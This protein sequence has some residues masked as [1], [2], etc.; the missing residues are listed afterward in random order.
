MIE[1]YRITKEQFNKLPQLDRIE[2]T[3]RYKGIKDYYD[4]SA[5]FNILKMFFFPLIFVM[6]LLYIGFMVDAELNILTDLLEKIIITFVIMG[7]IG[8]PI[9]FIL[10]SRER[11]EL[12]ALEEEYFN[13]KSEVKNATKSR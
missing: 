8:L 12:K 3:I 9:D 5:C 7:M 10:A 11:N 4:Y 13:F 6:G 1:N 2:Y